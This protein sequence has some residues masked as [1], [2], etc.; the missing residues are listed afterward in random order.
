MH[1][2]PPAHALAVS[3]AL[4]LAAPAPASARVRMEWQRA[5]GAEQCLVE[6]DLV[7]SIEAALGSPV[8]SEGALDVQIRGEVQPREGGGFSA[9]LVLEDGQGARVG[10]RELTEEDPTCARLTESVALVLSLALLPLLHEAPA[11]SPPWRGGLAVQAVGTVG[12]LPRPDAGFGLTARLEPPRLWPLELS[13][14][15]WLPVRSPDQGPGG[16]LRLWDLGLSTA[17]GLA[18]WSWGELEL[19]AGARVLHFQAIGVGL[20]QPERSATFVPTL[21]AGVRA[22]ARLGARWR[23]SLELGAEV[24]LTR[25]V[26]SYELGGERVV[27]FQV[28]PVVGRLGLGLEIALP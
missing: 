9:R 18:S 25:P 14:T 21:G 6:A 4:L 5:S 8:F 16:L 1:Q 7:R 24:P 3:L 11:P 15:F 26:L 27:L 28:S 19:V 13:G 12:L 20:E 2:A 22:A 23:L 17:P 10:Q